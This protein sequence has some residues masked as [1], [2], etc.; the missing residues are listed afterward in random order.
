MCIQAESVHYIL[1]MYKLCQLYCDKTEKIINY[2]HENTP[3]FFNTVYYYY[4]E[5]ICL[6]HFKV[7]CTVLKAFE[8]AQVWKLLSDS[9]NSLLH[10]SDPLSDQETSWLPPGK[11]PPAPARPVPTPVH[12][13]VNLLFYL[14][15][16]FPPTESSSIVC[17]WLLSPDNIFWDLSILYV[18]DHLFL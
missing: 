18:I 12:S 9:L 17:V 3:K 1:W 10:W 15:Q 7:K 2:K 5:F 11:Y 6:W 16:N 13:Q 8:N 14:F 4:P